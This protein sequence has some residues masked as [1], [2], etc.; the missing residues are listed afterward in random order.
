MDFLSQVFLFVLSELSH[1]VLPRKKFQAHH[2]V[3]QKEL[4]A[5]LKQ[6]A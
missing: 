4:E 3:G 1:I 5:S 6:H 2:L